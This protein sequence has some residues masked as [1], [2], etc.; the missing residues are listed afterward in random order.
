DRVG[1]GRRVRGVP[2]DRGGAAA[3]G[4]ARRRRR[5]RGP[6]RRGPGARAARRA[7]RGAGA[8]AGAAGRRHAVPASRPRRP[9]AGR[10]GGAARG[11][12]QWFAGCWRTAELRAALGAYAGASLR[13]LLGP[14]GPVAV[15]PPREP[16]PAWYDCDTPEDLAAAERLL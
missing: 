1:G 7:G 5:P 16:R 14:L 6:A 8:P 4:A 3:R 15:A 10:D 2:A 11:R 9:A 13:G 12:E